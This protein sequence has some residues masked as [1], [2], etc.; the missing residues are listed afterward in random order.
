M[1]WQEKGKKI[2][3]VNKNNYKHIREYLQRPGSVR[4]QGVEAGDKRR[5]ERYWWHRIASHRIALH[6]VK[7]QVNRAE[8]KARVLF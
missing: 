1:R 8:S 3:T 5:F 2:N 7:V 6:C 4:V